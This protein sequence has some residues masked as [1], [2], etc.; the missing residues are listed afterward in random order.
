MGTVQGARRQAGTDFEMFIN[1]GNVFCREIPFS[2]WSCY[3]VIWAL[4][5]NRNL[6]RLMVFNH[7]ITKIM[8]IQ[9]VRRGR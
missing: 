4:R 3:P 6:E 5:M 9:I 7:D 2:H 1:K 8:G